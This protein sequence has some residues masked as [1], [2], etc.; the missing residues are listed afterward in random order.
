MAKKHFVTII[1]LLLLSTALQA[2]TNHITHAQEAQSDLIFFYSQ[3]NDENYSEINASRINEDRS[4]LSVDNDVAAINSLGFGNTIIFASQQDNSN[5]FTIHPKGVPHSVTSSLQVGVLFEEDFSDNAADWETIENENSLATIEDG[6]FRIEINEG[7]DEVV[8]PGFND[9]TKAPIFSGNYEFE[10]TISNLENASNNY[11]IGA[12][13]DVKEAQEAY[14]RFDICTDGIWRFHHI[15]NRDKATIFFEYQYEYR[16]S[17]LLDGR[18]YQIKVKI[19]DN[20][21]EFYANDNFITA[22]TDY[23]PTNGSIGL[24]LSPYEPDTKT[25]ASVNFD[26]LI[27]RALD[28]SGVA[29][30]PTNTPTSAPTVTVAPSGTVLDIGQTIESTLGD[31]DE[32]TFQG[33]AGQSIVIFMETQ[34]EPG[35]FDLKSPSDHFE[36]ADRDLSGE[37]S[38]QLGPYTLPETGNYTIT[39]SLDDANTLYTLSVLEVPTIT[40]RQTI[41]GNLISGRT[42]YYFFEASNGEEVTITAETQ[43]FDIAI[44]LY[45][46][47]GEFLTFDPGIDRSPVSIQE[48]L[49]SSGR[50]RLDVNAYYSDSF[51]AGH[52]TLTMN[53]QVPPTATPFPTRTPFPTET[54]APTPT[55]PVVESIPGVN[56]TLTEIYIDQ[57][58]EYGIYYPAGWSVYPIEDQPLVF[59]LANKSGI[60]PFSDPNPDEIRVL[61]SAGTRLSDQDEYAMT[62][63]AISEMISGIQPTET[64]LYSIDGK[65]AAVN[66]FYTGQSNEVNGGAIVSAYSPDRFVI[67]IATA[68]TPEQWAANRETVMSIVASGHAPSDAD[69][70]AGRTVVTL[71]DPVEDLILYPTASFVLG[72]PD[73]FSEGFLEGAPDL[74]ALTTIFGFGATITG[75]EGDP[76]PLAIYVTKVNNPELGTVGSL[77]TNSSM[78]VNPGT[79]E[80][81]NINGRPG[82]AVEGT[83]AVLP[84]AQII[85]ITVKAENGDIYLIG[86][87]RIGPKID[88]SLRP[89]LYSIAASVR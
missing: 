27:V 76:S 39:V 42:D 72:Y 89:Y 79:L 75:P 57:M 10:F 80:L 25:T 35:Y 56:D 82:A 84:G 14:K 73:N 15:E 71:S 38:T 11:C 26:N 22:F 9:W 48:L 46:P 70:A 59:V 74:G 36:Y 66:D 31:E 49:T 8:A 67:G 63:R 87:F 83:M 64:R 65:L 24:A 78:A 5:D 16:L 81:L 28:S 68:G 50:Y 52:Y 69:L 37:K 21:Y 77:I 44:N 6:H 30:A 7:T 29:L 23:Q 40:N 3:L 45:D 33:N 85:F 43:N 13:F 53:L 19:I 34:A 1:V 51:G 86:A 2:S 20:D 32:W 58:M 60:D 62:N 55:R 12:V 18:S 88:D 54:P 61:F 17:D 47:S 41:Q 4:S